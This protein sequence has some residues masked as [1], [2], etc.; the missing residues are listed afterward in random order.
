MPMLLGLCLVALAGCAAQTTTTAAQSQTPALVPGSARVWF[1]RE[2]DPANG[3][4]Q[5]AAPMVFANGAPVAR[6]S[7][8]AVFYRDFAPG[9]YSLT[10]E[11]F[12]GLPT[13]QADTIQL[14][15]GT[16]SYLHV[17]WLSSWE[18]GY[19]EADFSV[20]PNTFGIL[21]IAPEVG[22]AYI[23]PLTYLGQR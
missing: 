3:N 9:T 19:P 14:A 13:G 4:D 17:Q 10:V 22:R 6:S 16:Q 21:T 5:A 2:S 8:G 12:G 7:A 20:D 15:A 11:P 23:P 18:V 1:L